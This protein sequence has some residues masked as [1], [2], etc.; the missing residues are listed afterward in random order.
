MT[1]LLSRPK[2]MVLGELPAIQ[3]LLLMGLGGLAVR[4]S[5]ATLAVHW[6]SKENCSGVR[7]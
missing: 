2:I 1:F 4:V 6:A 7:Q 5:L 3:Y